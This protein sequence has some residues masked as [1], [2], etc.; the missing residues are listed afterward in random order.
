M[1]LRC[2]VVFVL[3]G[4]WTIVS[5]EEAVVYETFAGV[6]IGRVFLTPGDRARLDE[7]RLHPPAAAVGDEP[8]TEGAT[9]TRRS[10]PSAGYIISSSGRARVWHDGDFVE[11]R[12][13][14]PR[15]MQF[16]GDVKVIRSVPEDTPGAA[17]EEDQQ[18]RRS[19]ADDDAD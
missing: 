18:E 10:L 15:N 1:L 9:E 11:S 12:Q 3:L 19:E 16:P 14:T 2:L 17:Q 6:K 7:Q 5:A 13:H 8:A 4:N